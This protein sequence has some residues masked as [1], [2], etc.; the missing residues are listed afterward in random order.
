MSITSFLFFILSFTFILSQSTFSQDLASQKF[1]LAQTLEQTGQINDAA[2]VYLELYEMDKNNKSYFEGLVRNYRAIGK[3]S[4]L[5]SIVSEKIEKDKAPELLIL[6]GELL[7]RTGNLNEAEKSWDKANEQFKGNQNYYFQLFAV[8]SELQLF[9]KAIATIINGRKKLES[10]NLWS[11]ELSKLYIATGNYKDGAVEVVNNLMINTNLP[12]AQGRIYALANNETAIEHLDKYLNNL[13]RKEDKNVFIQELYA[14]FLKTMNKYDTA[15]ETFVRL[16]ELKGG[17]G[18]EI[19]SFANNCKD[20][21]KFEIAL[22][23]FEI[24]ID[25]GKKSS[26][27]NQALFGFAQTLEMKYKSGASLDEKQAKDIIER[28]RLIIKDNPKSSV[29]ADAQFRIAQIYY[30]NL[31]DKKAAIKEAEDVIKNHQRLSISAQIMNWI[32]DIYLKDGDF[33]TAEKYYKE[34]IKSYQKISPKEYETANF[35]L[36]ELLFYNGEVEESAKQYKAI[37]IYYSSSTSNNA[38]DRMVMLDKYMDYIDELKLIGK[39]EFEEFRG[40]REG[41]KTLYEKV[42]LKAYE[43][44]TEDMMYRI[45][46]IYFEQ[47]KYDESKK[48]LNT[49]LEKYPSSIFGDQTYYLLAQNQIAENENEK[50]IESLT[51][52]LVKYTNSILTQ[53][54][55]ALIRKLRGEFN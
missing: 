33:I 49:L 39:A 11:D 43:D 4:D 29:A 51:Q 41:A 7:W 47:K 21:A 20:E 50:A 8:Q 24:V 14:W 17:N 9:E 34:V 55:R 36:A 30:Y 52:I 46:K 18:W 32:G 44:I 40:N 53:E 48:E 27:F 6:N 38:L 16:D 37:S 45:G 22:K 12:S 26:Y 15:L 13:A 31:N 5:L 25:R 19:V 42:K 3:Y 10:K 35:R 23:A 28:Y 54:T 2:R 1:R